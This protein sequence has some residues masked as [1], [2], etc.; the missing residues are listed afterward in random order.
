MRRSVR[1]RLQI[2]LAGVVLLSGGCGGFLGGADSDTD[3]RDAFDRGLAGQQRGRP[4]PMRAAMP[5]AW[6]TIW[7][8]DGYITDDMIEDEVGAAWDGAPD[9][10]PEEATAVVVKG[11]GERVRGFMW[12]TGDVF[13]SCLPYFLP[14]RPG[15]SFVLL[16]PV[17]GEDPSRNELSRAA[18]KPRRDCFRYSV[19]GEDP[20]PPPPPRFSGGSR[21]T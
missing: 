17:S 8:F 14:V 18:T 4:F 19:N 15:D 11:P 3:L 16:G 10:I 12:D 2:A 21:R 13:S 9:E 5:G 1:S 7:F 6:T 20:P